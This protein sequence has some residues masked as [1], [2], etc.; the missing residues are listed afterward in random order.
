MDKIG[1][2]WTNWKL[3]KIENGSKLKIRQKLKQD[4]IEIVDKW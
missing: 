2:I 3:D 4:K 1:Q